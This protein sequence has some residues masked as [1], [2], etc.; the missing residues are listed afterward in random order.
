MRAIWLR[1]VRRA[2][3]GAAEHTPTLTSGIYAGWAH[4]GP[5]AL[6]DE[7]DV[8][9]VPGAADDRWPGYL[10]NSVRGGAPQC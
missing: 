5:A 4:L 6:R 1:D 7:A 10:D 9:S 2:F 8:R 3:D